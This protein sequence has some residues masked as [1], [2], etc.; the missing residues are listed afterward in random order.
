MSAENFPLVTV[1]CNCY[2]HAAYL[3]EALDSVINQSYTNIELIVIN[4]GS[5]D[6]SGNVIREFLKRHP[7][8]VFLDLQVSTS[9]NKAFNRAF[10]ISKGDFLI[11]LSGDDVLLPDC[12]TNQVDF[13]LTQPKDVGI[14]FGNA[15]IIDEEGR[16]KYNY[17][18]V[19]D[20]NSKVL[21]KNLFETSY[22]SI[23]AGGMCMCSVSAMMRRSQFEMLNGYDERLIFEDLDYWLRLSYQYRIVFLDKFL[24]EKRELSNSLGSF[25]H[26][27][28]DFAKKMNRSLQIIYQDAILRNNLSENRC[29]LKRIH[30][31]MEQCYKC[32]NWKDLFMFSLLELK[33]RKRIYF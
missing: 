15:K 5:A 23:L 30:Y 6:N 16:F 7:T 25:F 28:T 11:D 20:I 33:C 19:D 8:V 4:N 32:R 14:I 22:K 21:D 1:I 24:V 10:A 2:N 9:H 12:I 17:F 31:S 13:F 18:S 29:V 27:K 26:Q 3:R